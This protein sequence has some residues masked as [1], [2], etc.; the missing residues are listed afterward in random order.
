V[1]S[2]LRDQLASLERHGS[3]AVSLR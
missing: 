3:R 2:E 1:F